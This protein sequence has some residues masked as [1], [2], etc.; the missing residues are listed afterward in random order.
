MIFLYASST[1]LLQMNVSILCFIQEDTN[2]IFVRFF[3]RFSGKARVFLRSLNCEEGWNYDVLTRHICSVLFDIL[4]CN[5]SAFQN[6]IIEMLLTGF[7]SSDL[8]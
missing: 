4:Y 2:D 5:P 1:I 6:R 7:F 8:K 3:Y